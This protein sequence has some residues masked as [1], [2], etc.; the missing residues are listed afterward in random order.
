[1]SS[2]TRNCVKHQL[3][4]RRQASGGTTQRNYTPPGEGFLYLFKGG[5]FAT[6]G[7]SGTLTP[8][9][10]DAPAEQRE[11][12]PEAAD[13]RRHRPRPRARLTE[14]APAAPSG[15]D[16]MTVSTTPIYWT[17]QLDHQRR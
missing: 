13:L 2:I 1:M 11:A 14:R 10:I 16:P 3:E 15:H 5:G 17:T 7:A 4:L 8:A 6:A 9:G 12:G